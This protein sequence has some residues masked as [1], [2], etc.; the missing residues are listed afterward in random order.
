MTDNHGAVDH[1]SKAENHHG[2]ED[3]AEDHQSREEDPHGGANGAEHPHGGAE[4]H[5]G[6]VTG[7]TKGP[8]IDALTEAVETNS[9]KSDTFG[10]TGQANNP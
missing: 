10:R 9:S 2:R 3:G 4:N 6:R 8:N 1:Q 7:Q 5:H